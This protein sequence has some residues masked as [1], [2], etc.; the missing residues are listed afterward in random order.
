MAR[1]RIGF[2]EEA[3]GYYYFDADNLEQAQQFINE[4]EEGDRDTDDLPEFYQKTNGG[5]HEWISDLEEVK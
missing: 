3:Y 1:F 4:I 2:S 5:Q